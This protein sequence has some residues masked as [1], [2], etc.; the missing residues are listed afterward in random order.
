MPKS[1][2]WKELEQILGS[3]HL[4]VLAGRQLQQDF[5]NADN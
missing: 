4:F 1:S 2:L 5:G 3:Y